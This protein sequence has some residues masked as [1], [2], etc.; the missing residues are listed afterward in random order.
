MIKKSSSP[1][2]FCGFTAACLPWYKQ[3]VR[4]STQWSKTGPCD[5][6]LSKARFQEIEVTRNRDG[7]TK[8]VKRY[9]PQCFS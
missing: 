5:V 6:R 3:Q 1:N 8:K 7:N 4:R 9:C 2:R